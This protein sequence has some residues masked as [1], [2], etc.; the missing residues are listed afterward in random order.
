MMVRSG[1]TLV[2]LGCW[3][4]MVPACA[5]MHGGDSANPQSNPVPPPEMRPTNQTATT[6]PRSDSPYHSAPGSSDGQSSQQEAQRPVF[7]INDK[8]NPTGL[9]GDPNDPNARIPSTYR[10]TSP[11]PAKVDAD[12][13]IKAEFNPGN[14]VEN[15]LKEP[16]F[17]PNAGMSPETQGS[18]LPTKPAAETTGSSQVIYPSQQ[19]DERSKG[20]PRGQSK[21]SPLGIHASTSK[22]IPPSSALNC[23]DKTRQDLL[24][25]LLS[26]GGGLTEGDTTK[27]DPQQAEI[28]VSQLHSTV[29]PGRGAVAFKYDAPTHRSRLRRL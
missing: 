3:L 24:F 26:N 8:P 18:G 13:E 15:R 7:N 17:P 14:N 11:V 2:G 9:T 29:S 10:S 20:E 1:F 16:R 25:G 6:R 27:I 4:V 12:P 21:E 28:I 19:A 5:W 23:Y 22:S